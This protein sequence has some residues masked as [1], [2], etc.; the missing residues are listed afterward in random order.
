VYSL[1]GALD[2][3]TTHSWVI[4]N[5]E[6]TEVE[7]LTDLE[8]ITFPAPLG[9]LEAFHT[10]GG[11][12]TM[13]WTYADKVDLMEYKTMR[14][15]GHAYIMKAIRD[16]GLLDLEPVQVDGIEVAPRDVFI[17]RVDRDLRI[18]D[19]PDIVA[20]KV[21]VEGHRDGTPGRI[22]FRLLDGYDAEH[23]ISAMMRT[24]GFSLAITGYM[25]ANGDIDEL[26]VRCAYEAMPYR[27]YADALRHRGVS[28][29]EVEE[30]LLA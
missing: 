8:D 24:T 13:P 22:T 16:L 3:Y 21:V 4:R 6:P 26:G 19:A 11:L 7:A 28:I 12:S 5:G 30:S 18:P 29:V 1:E 9:T 17:A 20:L 23:G 15:P 10:A 14:Y 2:Y 27:P 25:Q